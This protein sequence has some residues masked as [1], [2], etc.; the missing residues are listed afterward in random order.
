MDR[1]EMARVVKGALIK[2][3]MMILGEEILDPRVG[4]MDGAKGKV[5]R[6]QVGPP[7][8]LGSPVGSIGGPRVGWRGGARPGRCFWL[9]CM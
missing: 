4:I 7:K 2:G 6:G 9:P 3:F 5:A 8:F 1:K